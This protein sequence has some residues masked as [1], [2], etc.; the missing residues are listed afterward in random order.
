MKPRRLAFL[1]GVRGLARCGW[2]CSMPPPGTTSGSSRQR[3]PTAARQALRG[4]FR[5]PMFFVLSGFVIAYAVRGIASTPP[6]SAALRCGARSGSPAVLGV[7]RR[8]DRVPGDEG[9]PHTRRSRCPPPESSPRMRSI[10]RTFLACIKST[11][12]TGRCATKCSSTCCFACSSLPRSAPVPGLCRRGGRVA[13]LASRR[14]ARAR[15]LPAVLARL[16]P[17]RLH[18]LGPCKAAAPR[19]LCPLCRR[20]RRSVAVVA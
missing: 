9:L 14:S 16:P 11:R 5:G 19:G 4:H 20:A 18:L 7:D 1:D 6:I 10:C 3:C 13:R 8:G 17:R 15:P 12:C 2:C